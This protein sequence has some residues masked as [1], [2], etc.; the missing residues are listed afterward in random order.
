MARCEF[1]A[2][3]TWALARRFTIATIHGLLS[4]SLLAWGR[5]TTTHFRGGE[6]A[7]ILFCKLSFIEWDKRLGTKVRT[8]MQPRLFL[9]SCLYKAAFIGE[10]WELLRY[11]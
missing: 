9:C 2:T 3:G 10:L 6:S 11:F 7:I 5:A 1:V 8:D 4:S